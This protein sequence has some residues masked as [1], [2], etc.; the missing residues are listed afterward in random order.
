[1]G[2]IWKHTLYRYAT[3]Q[4]IIN[5]LTN[6]RACKIRGYRTLRLR[7]ERHGIERYGEEIIERSLIG[8]KPWLYE[9]SQVQSTQAHK[10]IYYINGLLCFMI[11]LNKMNVKGFERC[12]IW[13]VLHT[14]EPK[15]VFGWQGQR[16]FINNTQRRIK[17]TQCEYTNTRTSNAKIYMNPTLG[18]E[19]GEIN[20]P[21]TQPQGSNRR[22]KE[23]GWWDR[24]R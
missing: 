12:Y 22:G 8:G 4:I 1:M 20:P 9:R 7:L 23:G 21:K 14:N 3:P 16:M 6:Q 2:K 18:K 13:L 24:T 11:W 19:V 17:D 10:Y 15:L 5:W